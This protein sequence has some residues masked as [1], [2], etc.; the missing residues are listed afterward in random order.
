MPAPIHIAYLV[1]RYPATNHTFILR[2][3]VSLREQGFQ[4]DVISIRGDDR[5]SSKL[6]AVERREKELVTTILPVAWPFV[7][8]Q[9][10]TLF[11][12]PLRYLRGLAY[13]LL[14]GGWD[15][16]AALFHLIY[17][18]EAVVVGHIMRV[19]GIGHM[20]SHFSSTVGL[21]A[22]RTFDLGLSITIHGPDEFNDVIGFHMREKVAQSRFLTTISH[23][24]SSQVMRATDPEF[25]SKVEVSRLGVDVSVFAPRP[26]RE[27][28]DRARIIFVGRLAPV[29]AQQVLIAACARLLA[30]GR[31]LELHLVGSGPD[32]ERLERYAASL[33]IGDKV[34]F[35]GARNQDEVVEL[36][37]QSDLFALASFAEGVPVVLMEAMA[38]E[39]PCVATWVNGIPELIR[40][41]EEG[42]LIA[43]S[44]VEQLAAAMERMLAD[45]AL[46]RRLA[47][48]GR[49]RVL[50]EYN[51]EENIGRLAE[52]FR[53]RLA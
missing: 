21:L 4:I 22:A 40:D 42:L 41:G 20:H 6:T 52:I 53:R 48:A 25:W 23:Y 1:S 12:S 3:I 38:M 19:R 36:Y 2:E 24:A 35:E 16:K 17:F 37:R 26:A 31:P 13:A 49:R 9:L 15:L 30:G 50:A 34:I 7:Q 18:L 27:G 45:P 44:S 33:G 14:L 47:Q 29:K 8:A 46:S 32:R 39:V 51:L 11:G 10:A 5:G 28:G 43:P